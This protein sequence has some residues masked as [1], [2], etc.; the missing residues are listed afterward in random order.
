MG[1]TKQELKRYARHIILSEVGLEGQ[2]KLKNSSVLIIGAG[3]LGSPV[4][5][6]LAAAG[7][8]TLGI[9]DFDTVDE[10]NLQ[11]QIIHKSSEIGKYK[12]DSAAKALYEINPHIKLN[13]YNYPISTE[14]AFE[15]IEP[16]DIVADGTDNFQTRYLV[17]DACVLLGKPNV[18]SSILQFDG[19]ASVFWGKKGPCY[20]CLFPVP[21][22]EGTVPSCSEA[23]VFGV[24]P[25]VMGSIQATE[26]LKLLLNIGETLIGRMLVYNAL[27]MEF[28]ELKLKKNPDCPVCG[29]YPTIT[30]L[31]TESVVCETT[32]IEPLSIKF[33][34]LAPIE[35]EKAIAEEK[36]IY[37]LDVREPYETEIC[38]IPGSVNIPMGRVSERINDIPADIDIVVI[39][40][41]G[42]RS[43]AITD[44][45]KDSGFSKVFNLTGGIDR[46]SIDV[47]PEL[48]RY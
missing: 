29:N 12:T 8:G 20:R 31:N 48:E 36:D 1:L 13:L 2:E 18:Y 35:L 14:N 16:Y 30:E 11:R 22:E 27:S 21:P 4:A 17:N 47:K 41:L 46:Y 24:L 19:Q 9:V 23:G 34:E 7:V 5:M 15:L 25:G 28:E 37:L 6:Y 42:V 40:H 3:G 33:D 38:S 10:S 43:R 32:P 26:A 45:L 39:C 44:M